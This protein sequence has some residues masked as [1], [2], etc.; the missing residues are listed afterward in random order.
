MSVS[1]CFWM[2]CTCWSLYLPG[3]HLDKTQHSQLHGR[4]V[5]H[6][7]SAQGGFHRRILG[8]RVGVRLHTHSKLFKHY[9][10]D[11][12]ILVPPP[13]PLQMPGSFCLSLPPSHL[14]SPTLPP[15]LPPSECFSRPQ[16]AGALK[17]RCPLSRG[18]TLNIFWTSLSHSLSFNEIHFRGLL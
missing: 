15:S 2:A 18:A 4:L 6:T 10:L 14:W 11:L 16:A 1:F 3:A 5:I 9:P 7:I 12:A 13:P 17:Y 8:Q